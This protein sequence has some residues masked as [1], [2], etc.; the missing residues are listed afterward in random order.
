M[1]AKSWDKGTDKLIFDESLY[2]VTKKEWIRKVKEG[3][4]VSEGGKQTEQ[5]K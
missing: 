5:K 1:A 3:D 4:S 2:S